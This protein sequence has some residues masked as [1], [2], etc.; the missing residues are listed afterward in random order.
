M[1]RP[2]LAP[3]PLALLLVGTLALAGCSSEEP[4]AAPATAS[5]DSVSSKELVT[6]FYTQAFVEGD[7]AG[8]ADEYIGDT[9]VQHNPQVD[10]GR[11]AYVEA[12]APYVAEPGVEYEIARVVAED[13]LVVVHALNTAEGAPATAVA[14]IFR[15]EDGKIVEHW[16]VQQEVPA[17]TVSGNDMVLD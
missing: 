9:Y 14:D 15:V 17:E 16:D 8:A 4:A 3:R 6:D 1:T 5:D 12:L 13:D 10:D 2:T 7:V 11:E